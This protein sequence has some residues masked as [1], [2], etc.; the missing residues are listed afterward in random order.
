MGRRIT[1]SA[2]PSSRRRKAGK[3]RARRSA[4]R[5]KRVYETPCPDDGVRVLV[6]RV[7]PRGLSKEEAKID[8]W[9][10]EVAPST[11]LRQWFGHDPARWTEFRRRY[12]AELEQNSEPLES[13]RSLIRGQPATL[14]YG[15]RDEQHNQAVVL[16]EILRRASL[17]MGTFLPSRASKPPRE[18]SGNGRS[19]G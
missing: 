7:W 4:V 15:A 18:R 12:R 14:L 16:V 6:D 11:A 5:V 10:K 13:L 8:H 19:G 9:L 3:A 2:M 1:F 17:R